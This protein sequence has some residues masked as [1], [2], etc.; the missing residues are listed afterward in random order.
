MDKALGLL[1][2]ACRQGCQY[3]KAGVFVSELVTTSARQADL[4]EA[5]PA[6]TEDGIRSE[7]LKALMDQVNR[8]SRG[9]LTTARQ[10]GNKAYAMRR[11][12]LSPAYTTDR[13]QAGQRIC[14]SRSAAGDDSS[15]YSLC[16][17]L[18]VR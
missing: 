4:F 9:A 12:H 6:E 18:S 14:G 10:A 5:E 16:R 3:A 15:L 1:R 11:S 7:R 17:F 2:S 8:Q 13:H